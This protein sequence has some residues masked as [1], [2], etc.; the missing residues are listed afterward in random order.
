MEY[1][2]RPQFFENG[3]PPHFFKNGIQ[4]QLVQS[5]IGL[6]KLLVSVADTVLK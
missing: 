2:G 6:V 1:K 3:R 5:T 4:T